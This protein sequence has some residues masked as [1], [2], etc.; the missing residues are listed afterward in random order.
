MQ[1]SPLS[2]RELLDFL[3]NA[4]SRYPVETWEIASVHV[5]PLIKID[6][7]FRHVKSE[8][9]DEA[10]NALL[11]KPSK[12]NRIKVLAKA[13]GSLLR[14]LLLFLKKKKQV[15]AF[16]SD[17]EGHRVVHHEAFINR[18]F[19]PI[20][21]HLESEDSEFNYLSISDDKGNLKRYPS[22]EPVFFAHQ[23]LLGA[24]LWRKLFS[25][26][27]GRSK[28]DGY[29]KF[30][31]ELND[32]RFRHLQVGEKY[33]TQVRRKIGDV[34][35]YSAIIHLLIK[36]YKP[37]VIFELCYYSTLRFGINHAA[38]QTGVRTV[39]IQHGGM[40]RDHVSYSGWSKLPTGGYNLLPATFW[41]WDESSKHLIEKWV[42]N[43]KYHSAIV[44]GNPWLPYVKESGEMYS[45][46]TNRNI[47]LYTLQYSEI[48]DHIID[49]IKSTPDRFQWWIRLH[50]RKL[51]SKPIINK[52]LLDSGVQFDCF[53]IEK[54][55]YYPL[56]TIL[57]NTHIHLSGSSGSIIE[58]AQI[59][60]PSIILEEIGTV[61]YRDLIRQ[62][63]ATALFSTDEILNA[64]LKIERTT[65][66]SLQEHT[67]KSIVEKL[68]N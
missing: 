47:I 8:G 20:I 61:Y 33:P 14:F 49:A 15:H 67:Y 42:K 56:P 54:A 12:P 44:G 41:L 64:I 21:E 50:P 29:N 13:A 32:S 34:L 27:K 30:I 39:E 7:F 48:P 45:F 31:A 4:E 28:L 58:A 59:G 38:F 35:A 6:L 36:K 17:S 55:T 52:L 43:N 25:R 1:H 11:P 9:K 3:D 19:K 46:P 66:E 26:N 40:G 57:L 37:R 5:W 24:K 16:F 22:N 65:L 18:Y 51:E 60:V 10:L 63:K 53:E 2:R 23:Y 62:G 68:I